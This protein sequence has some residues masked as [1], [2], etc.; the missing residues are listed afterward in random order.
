MTTIFSPTFAEAVSVFP[1]AETAAVLPEG[2]LSF[3]TE[4]NL[5]FA[6]VSK[7][8]IRAIEKQE[9][10]RFFPRLTRCSALIRG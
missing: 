3:Y 2:A 9:G 1:S 5:F 4:S 6:A 7:D 10:W 8:F